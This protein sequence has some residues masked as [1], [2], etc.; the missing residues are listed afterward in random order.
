MPLTTD[1]A[2]NAECSAMRNMSRV[3]EM[4]IDA[5]IQLL[6]FQ[7]QAAE[8]A[9]AEIRDV[10]DQLKTVHDWPALAALPG[11]LSKVQTGHIPR[12]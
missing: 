7:L 11:A 12:S 5:Q 2:L 8:E 6:R 9:L 4:W 3:G 10:Q 1:M